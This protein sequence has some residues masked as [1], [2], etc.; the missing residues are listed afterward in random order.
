MTY[1]PYEPGGSSPA[2]SAGPAD[3]A[4]SV[5]PA[6]SY[7]VYDAGAVNDYSSGST[8][9]SA[10]GSHPTPYSRSRSGGSRSGSSVGGIIG[11]VI[12]LVAV[13]VGLAQND[14]ARDDDPS[15]QD[16]TS[17][18]SCALEHDETSSLFSDAEWC[19]LELN[20]GNGDGLGN[21]DPYGLDDKDPYGLDDDPFGL[22][23]APYGYDDGSGFP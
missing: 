15:Y 22:D 18:S 19:D 17:Y 7:D 3:S 1:E 21:E 11:G 23:D 9:R 2:E 20:G 10:A 12:G 13:V 14:D 5:A 8:L 4:D 6:P 16:R